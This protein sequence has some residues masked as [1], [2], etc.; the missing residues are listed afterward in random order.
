MNFPQVLGSII[1]GMIHTNYVQPHY[2]TGL[3]YVKNALYNKNKE[4]REAL[5]AK[6]ITALG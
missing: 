6:N 5:S 1:S 2:N 4:Y 3:Q